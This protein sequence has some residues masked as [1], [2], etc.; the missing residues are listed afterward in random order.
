[1][2]GSG[3]PGPGTTAQ[4]YPTLHRIVTD[5]DAFSASLLPAYRLRP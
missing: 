4:R 5:L 3:G 2:S 1:M